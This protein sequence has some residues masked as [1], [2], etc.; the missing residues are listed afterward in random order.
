MRRRAIPVSG[1]WRTAIEWSRDARRVDVGFWHTAEIILE[2]RGQT[3]E[4]WLGAN[5]AKVPKELLAEY[6]HA[7][8]EAAKV[9]VET[10]REKF[11]SLPK[12]EREAAHARAE[13]LNSWDVYRSFK[14]LSDTDWE[15]RCPACSSKAFLAGVKYGEELSNHQPEYETDEEEVEVFFVAE[16]FLCPSRELRLNNRQEIEAVGLDVDH[17]EM[18]LA[19]ENT[20]RNMVTTK[21]QKLASMRAMRDAPLADYLSTAQAMGGEAAPVA[22]PL[23]PGKPAI[24]PNPVP[25]SWAVK[26]LSQGI[27]YDRAPLPLSAHAL[28]AGGKISGTPKAG[29]LLPQA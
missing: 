9:R 29:N 21:G 15:T 4:E 6:E 20:S 5:Q 25:L 11:D 14:L 27:V 19:K 23:K 13:K 10:A 18:E 8:A 24:N 3:I 12:R 16:E 1:C 26:S 17:I 28:R 22:A 7:V 2:I